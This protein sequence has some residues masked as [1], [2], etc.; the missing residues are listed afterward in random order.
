[1]LDR[2]EINTLAT[3][4]DV[5]T[6][7]FSRAVLSDQAIALLGFQR[8]KQVS[9]H[10]REAWIAGDTAPMLT[11]AR[12]RGAEIFDG[13]LHEIYCEYKPL[14]DH[15]DTIGFKPTSVIDIGCGQA[16]PDLFVHR[17]F[18]PRF[19]LI[20]IE[21]TDEQYHFFKEEGSGY[22]S[23]QDAY[24]MLVDNGVTATKIKT[25]NPRKTPEKMAGVTGDMLT[26][27]YSCGFHYPVDE[28]ADLMVQTI[29]DGGAVVL[30]L[31]KRYLRRKPGALPHVLNAGTVEEIYE[32]ARSFRIMVRG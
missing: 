9:K 26:S 31:R 3:P 7:D 19:T 15:L 23:L 24:D 6:L 11:E 2:V 13:A 30:D 18:K 5:S 14:K 8:T 20:D 16:L 12:D 27:Y 25:I 29:E 1:M 4:E 21:E 10:S 28:Y 17:D 22:A 32:D